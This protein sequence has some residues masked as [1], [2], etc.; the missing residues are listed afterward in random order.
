MQDKNVHTDPC[1]VFSISALLDGN[2]LARDRKGRGQ[3]G[4]DMQ[5]RARLITRGAG[6]LLYVN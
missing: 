4:D 2:S 6:S 3:R 1:S 5:Q